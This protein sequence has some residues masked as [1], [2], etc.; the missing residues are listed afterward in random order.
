MIL[1]LIA[2]P[3]SFAAGFATALVFVWAEHRQ[4]LYRQRLERVNAA[5]FDDERRGAPAPRT[6]DPGISEKVTR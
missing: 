4:R 6:P 3:L 2:G 5:R 1:P